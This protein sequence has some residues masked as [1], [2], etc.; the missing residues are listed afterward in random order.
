MSW[1][2]RSASQCSIAVW[3]CQARLHYVTR[4]SRSSAHSAAAWWWAEMLAPLDG[5]SQAARTL[6]ELSRVAQLLHEPVLA[7]AANVHRREPGARDGGQEGVDDSE[8]CIDQQAGRQ[9]CCEQPLLAASE[10]GG[11]R[12]GR[13]IDCA[14]EE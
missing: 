3:G 4:P 6:A 10:R 7:Q 13:K 8:L 1:R 12:P 9:D 2:G 5:T 14:H 11:L